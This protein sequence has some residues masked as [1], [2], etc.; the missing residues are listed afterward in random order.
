MCIR[1]RYKVK[2]LR[3]SR[4]SGE[5]VLDPVDHQIKL[6]VRELESTL[7]PP[8]L[9]KLVSTYDGLIDLHHRLS[10][11][12]SKKGLAIA[13][14]ET[15]LGSQ[16]PTKDVR[17]LI[18]NKQQRAV[19]Q[20]P[21]SF[22]A[23]RVQPPTRSGQPQA[24]S[25]KAWVQSAMKLLHQSNKSLLKSA[26]LRQAAADY[27]ASRVD[28]A[29]LGRERL[30]QVI[31]VSIGELDT[32][33]AELN[34]G[35]AEIDKDMAADW[36][37]INEI[38]C[39]IPG[40]QAPLELAEARL[41]KRSRRPKPERVRDSAEKALEAEVQSLGLSLAKLRKK[42]K[43]MEANS[44]R[45]LKIKQEIQH[46]ILSKQ[47]SI[48]INHKCI[49]VLLASDEHTGLVPDTTALKIKE[50]KKVLS[51]KLRTS[52]QLFYAGDTDMDSKLTLDEFNRG[53]SMMGVRE[54]PADLRAVFDSLDTDN[55]GLIDWHD[56]EAVF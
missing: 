29:G 24:L 12:A 15:C 46:D 45:L 17:S 2:Q 18:G 23:V 26:E 32:A 28:I 52:G 35:Q 39:S 7:Y 11:D 37:E 13:V 34:A 20:A 53:L 44:N 50:I 31:E 42:Q 9:K 21:R 4:P 38:T 1:D 27:R 6:F 25:S 33:V 56:M 3:L 47:E 40:I 8:R 30:V 43:K 19:K 16:S 55:D 10:E 41:L 22:D 51:A 14:D 48:Q 5:R 54:P 49:D 36:S